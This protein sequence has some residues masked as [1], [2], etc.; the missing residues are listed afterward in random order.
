[1]A[2]EELI[3]QMTKAIYA[4]LGQMVDAQLVEDIVADVYRI[5]ERE[6][7]TS[8]RGS[9][10]GGGVRIVVSAFGTNRPGVVAAIA[11]TLAEANYNIVD[12]NQTVVQGK[13]AMILIGETR[14]TEGSL[15]VLKEQLHAAGERVG[16]RVYAQREDLF[17]IM[18][19]I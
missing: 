5:V 12:M 2:P 19:R 17:Q 11:S 16:V 4:R 6:Y 14:D 1:M 8:S 10:L 9:E 15:A 7:D 18:H 13:F 3:Y